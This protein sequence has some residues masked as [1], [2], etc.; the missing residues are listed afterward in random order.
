MA[1]V[2]ENFKDACNPPGSKLDIGLM[3]QGIALF[4]VSCQE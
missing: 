1:P 2:L 4:V 3:H